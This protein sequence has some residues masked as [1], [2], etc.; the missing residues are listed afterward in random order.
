LPRIRAVIFDYIGTL[1]SPR[2]YTMDDSIAKL[3][4]ALAEAGFNT[5][6]APF[7]KAYNEAHEK[8]R[9]V[10]FGELREVTNAVWVS[11]TLC[12][13]GF[14][15]DVEN[16][17]VKRALDVFFQDYIDSLELRR[18]AEALLRRV[19]EN[20]KVGLASNFTYAPVVRKSIRQLGISG[21]FDAVV[22]SQECGWRKP[23]TKIFADALTLLGVK[24]T[25]A[26]FVG[27]NPEEDIKGAAEAGLRTVFVESQF[28]S[29]K[30]LRANGVKTDFVAKDLEE[31]GKRL[32][33]ILSPK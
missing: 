10:R 31:I 5:E 14:Q 2:R 18:G 24:A 17:A 29:Q 1:A 6:K 16:A 15:V 4:S 8:Y 30:D 26:V 21:C 27:D 3:H 32:P 9:K 13:L 25:E 7:V 28:F 11:E 33:E 22:V 23:H 20:C 19:R 12:N